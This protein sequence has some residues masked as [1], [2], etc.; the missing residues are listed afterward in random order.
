LIDQRIQ[1]GSNRPIPFR[2]VL[3]VDHQTPATS[4]PWNVLISQAAGPFH[5]PAGGVVPIGNG[6][7]NLQGNSLD[8]N[9]IGPLLLEAWDPTDTAD[10][11]SR[12]IE[13]VASD[14]VCPVTLGNNSYP[15]TFLMVNSADNVTGLQGL[16]PTVKI[17]KPGGSFAVPAGSVFEVGVGPNGGIHN[18]GRGWYWITPNATDYNTQGPLLLNATNTGAVTASDMWDVVGS[19]YGDNDRFTLTLI[20]LKERLV[21]SGLFTNATCVISLS[22]EP[23]TEPS[24]PCCWITPGEVPFDGYLLT[25]GGRYQVLGHADFTI[26]IILRR[27]SD[28]DEHDI[29]FLTSPAN[30]GYPFVYQ[31][32]NI[33]AED[34]LYDTSGQQLTTIGLKPIKVSRPYRYKNDK[35]MAV[36]ATSWKT[37]VLF[38]LGAPDPP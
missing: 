33:L 4:I 10:P 38:D 19:P 34:F 36:V 28:F 11:I 26:R 5:S 9:T 1:F 24:P 3:A 21:N 29:W 14:G 35:Q 32:V 31:L 30:G 20:A 18:M 37:D 12:R 7:Y 16:D 25:G 23:F 6:W 8:Q 22:D 13:I 2:G 15:M 27:A 17:C